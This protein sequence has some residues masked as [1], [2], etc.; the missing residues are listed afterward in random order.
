MLAKVSCWTKNNAKIYGVLATIFYI[1]LLPMSFGL[2]VMSP[3]VFDKPSMTT[4][5]GLIIIFFTWCIPTSL[6]VSLS[7]IWPKFLDEQYHTMR[8][9]ICLPLL[10][11][12]G[13]FCASLIVLWLI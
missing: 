4:F 8:F 1:L 9:Y 12:A 5:L 10:T 7:M 11:I 13:A 2:A 6:L 3:M